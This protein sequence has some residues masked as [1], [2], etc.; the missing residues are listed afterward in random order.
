M[1]SWW[2][3]DWPVG[4]SIFRYLLNRRGSPI[5]FTNL[6]SIKIVS[7]KTVV[8]TGTGQPAHLPNLV[9]DI[10][11][12]FSKPCFDK[13]EM[14]TPTCS[15][16]DCA[17][18]S[19]SLQ[20]EHMRHPIFPDVNSLSFY[21]CITTWQKLKSNSPFVLRHLF[22]RTILNDLRLVKLSKFCHDLFKKIMILQHNNRW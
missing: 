6:G 19:G 17:G 15:L 7:C 8:Y 13:R 9:R 14:F 2:W 12:L 18:W 20:S 3:V 21:F 11:F 4:S 16:S 10:T 5:L 22:Y 1:F